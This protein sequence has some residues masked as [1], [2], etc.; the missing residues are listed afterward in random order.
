MREITVLPKV[1]RCIRG[2]GTFNI[3]VLRLSETQSEA[4]CSILIRSTGEE[5]VKSETPNIYI[6]QQEAWGEEGYS[7]EITAEALVIGYGTV[8]GLFYAGITLKHLLKQYD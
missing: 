1:K 2:A 5:V 6:Q 3:G 7:L 4:A 8:K